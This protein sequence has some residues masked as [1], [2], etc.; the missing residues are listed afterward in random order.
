MRWATQALNYHGVNDSRCDKCIDF[1]SRHRVLREIRPSP[2]L[3]AG[4]TITTTRS[5]LS[6]TEIKKDPLAKAPPSG[7][8]GGTK[9]VRCYT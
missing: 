9:V 3:P 2:H 6:I 4:T 5:R 7:G 8:T 1:V